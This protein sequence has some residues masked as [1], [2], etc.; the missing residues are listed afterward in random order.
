MPA[1]S[2]RPGRAGAAAHRHRVRHRLRGRRRRRLPA[3]VRAEAAAARSSR[4]RSCWARSRGCCRRCRSCPSARPGSAVRCLPGS[5]TLVVANPAGRFAHV[6][7]DEP[8][9]IGVRVP[10]LRPAV[11]ALADAVGGLR[12]HQ[13]QPA[14]RPRPGASWRD[15]AGLA[16]RD[17]GV[18]GGRRPAAGR[19]VGG[20]RRQ[21]RGAD[22]ASARARAPMRRW[23]LLRV[24]GEPAP[25]ERLLDQERGAAAPAR[26]RPGR[27]RGAGRGP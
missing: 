8:S 25:I 11:A 6:C 18:R 19:A 24:G 26:S 4:P 22:A 7:G 10:G 20:D 27:G 13:R 12:H 15:G 1:S 21:R 23:R 3:A 9:R 16:A 17:G 2:W 5:L 14:R